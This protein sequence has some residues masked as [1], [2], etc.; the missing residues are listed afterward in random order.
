M[1]HFWLMIII[2]FT[3]SLNTPAHA[4]FGDLG[5]II[6][7]IKGTS[8]TS[9]QTPI[10]AETNV[11]T[12]SVTIHYDVPIPLDEHMITLSAYAPND[13]SGHSKQ[14]Q[15]L[16]QTR[17]M[18]DGLSSPLKLGVTVPNALIKKFPF[19]RIKAEVRDT[20][21]NR[22]MLSERESLYRG[23]QTPMLTLLP[24]TP[25]VKVQDTSQI[26]G[27]EQINGEV[28]FHS[29]RHK[30]KDGRLTVQLV[31]NA[32]AGSNSIT[33][34]AEKV[35]QISQVETSYP[36]S[37]DRALITSAPLTPLFLKAWVTDW[38]GRKTHI[39]RKPVPYNGADTEYRLMLD[40]LTQG[41]NTAAG[42]RMNPELMAQTSVHGEAMFDPSNGMPDDAKLKISLKKAVG[43]F[44]ENLG[45]SSQTIRV[46]LQ[47]RRVPF[48]L[49]TAST[50]FDPFI[51]API[52]TLEIVDNRGNI[53]Y[54]SGEIRAIEGPQVVQ[55][56]AR[57]SF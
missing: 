15:L 19:I 26:T 56:Y 53:F 3:A 2:I 49:T 32:L 25:D 24:T 52:L 17:L 40:A 12:I 44:G 27:L 22:V 41:K 18:L 29:K 51:P 16:G 48:S 57:P 5:D 28:V 23:K 45:L 33:I 50:N 10:Y 20:N 1:R 34:A 8:Q 54:D 6:K 43:A 47:D 37:L 21:N 9:N 4:Q 31:E 35:M 7:N 30:P 39:I 13:P 46:N 55:L 42:R 36:F 11:E 38:A 14:A